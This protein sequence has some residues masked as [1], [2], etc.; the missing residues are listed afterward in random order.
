MKLYPYC[1]NHRRFVCFQRSDT[2]IWCLRILVFFTPI[3]NWNVMAVDVSYADVFWS[4]I[5]FFSFWMLS[6]LTKRNLMIVCV[7][8]VRNKWSC[9]LPRLYIQRFFGFQRSDIRMWC[10]GQILGYVACES[11]KIVFQ[12]VNQLI[13][14]V[15]NLFN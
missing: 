13:W 9:V 7:E 6:S 8:Y 2:R 14:F 3:E 10:S 4:A 11:L 12:L 1:K 5:R 15:M